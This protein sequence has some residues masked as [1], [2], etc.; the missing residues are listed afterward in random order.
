[1][2]PFAGI[3]Q[4]IGK[5]GA[6][7]Y[8][9]VQQQRDDRIKELE[10]R[11]IA[12]QEQAVEGLK[13]NAQR[14]IAAIH[15]PKL[16]EETESAFD[17]AWA[18]G[19]Y[20]GAAQVMPRLERNYRIRT[21]LNQ[22]IG[23]SGD[24]KEQATLRDMM[25]VFDLDDLS[26]GDFGSG[27]KAY[28]GYLSDTRQFD[29]ATALENLRAK[30]DAEKAEKEHGYKMEENAA[31]YGERG[32]LVPIGG[33]TT[34]PTGFRRGNTILVPGGPGWTPDLQ[35][36]LDDETV[37]YNKGQQDKL[38]Q[39]TKLAKARSQIGANLDPAALDQAAERYAMTGTLP[40]LG[41]GASDVR[42]QIMNRAGQLYPTGSIVANSA[43]YKANTASL[44]NLVK[45]SDQVDAFE[46]TAGKNLDQFLGTAQKV[47]DS[48]VPLINTPVR[49]IVGG[50]GGPNQAVFNA[51]RTVA[52]T[53]ISRVL[54]SPNAAG[55]VSD[56][57]RKEVGSLITPN[58]NLAQIVQAANIL[59]S[60]MKNRQQ[61]YKEQ[62][63]DIK[64]RLKNAS[65]PP[66]PQTSG[67]PP[68][69]T[70]IVPG[71]DG[72]NHYTNDAGTVDLGI[73]P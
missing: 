59:R 5:A 66:Q 47:V 52:L 65:S 42:R 58:A 1:M 41:M 28:L 55:V 4:G 22:Q 73:A 63:A 70:K 29:N 54:N 49:A 48:G 69:A 3:A 7:F 67:V 68:G 8:D 40:Y 32:T 24:K 19:D 71:P 50:M 61:A 12:A 21:Y 20:Q 64:D 45:L 43:Q 36:A 26:N 23:N 60:D 13:Q 6:S 14:Q 11:R 62:I 2:G 27:L 35:R 9:A 57:A 46:N 31:L 53:E 18:R 72:N 30:N 37:S 56:S 39:A 33:Q 10:R 16:R 44:A 34:P 25:G 38:N 17:E 15:D 51:A